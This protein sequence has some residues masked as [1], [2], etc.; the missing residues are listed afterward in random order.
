MARNAR[1]CRENFRFQGL[2]PEATGKPRKRAEQMRFLVEMMASRLI[3]HRPGRREPRAVKRRP[4]PFPLLNKPRH[5]FV[6][7]PHRSRYRKVA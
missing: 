7:I 3:D 6:E 4:K 5:E 1:Y 2:T